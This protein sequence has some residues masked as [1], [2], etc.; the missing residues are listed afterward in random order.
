MKR[1]PAGIEYND[2]DV[3][4]FESL[5]KLYHKRLLYTA[6][7]ILKDH[8]EAENAVQEAWIGI[9]NHLD[10]IED[11]FSR[12]TFYYL[13]TA[14]RNVAI[15]MLYANK[16]WREYVNLETL[17]DFTDHTWEEA[18]NI[19]EQYDM[20][21]L[22]IE[23][24]KPHYRTILYLHFVEEWPVKEI[25]YFLN[26]KVSTVKQRLVRGKKMLLEHMSGGGT[27]RMQ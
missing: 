8:Q 15:N 14:T 10:K 13:L 9:A 1:Y 26:L 27:E 25:A 19:R 2:R 24:L 6:K 20:V 5:Y 21:V 22:Q 16:K 7:C 18:S 11:V 23:K 4:K 17:P 3:C 12:D